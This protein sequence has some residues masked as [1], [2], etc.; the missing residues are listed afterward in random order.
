MKIILYTISVFS[1]PFVCNLLETGNKTT[2][3]LPDIRERAIAFHDQYY[4]ASN[5]QL[6]ILSPYDYDSLREYVEQLFSVMPKRDLVLPPIS[7]RIMFSLF[8]LRN[9]L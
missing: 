3:T 6:V 4:V 7:V 1:T 8:F 9:H 5:M 2:L